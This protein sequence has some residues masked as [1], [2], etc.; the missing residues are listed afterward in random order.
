MPPEKGSEYLTCG[1]KKHMSQIIGLPHC[2]TAIRCD[3]W[4]CMLFETGVG[5]GR[6]GGAWL[7]LF[8]PAGCLFIKM[9][10]FH[11]PAPSSH[12]HSA[13]LW[14]VAA[15]TYIHTQLICIYFFQAESEGDIS[16]HETILI[17]LYCMKHLY[18]SVN[19]L[20]PCQSD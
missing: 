13:A 9:M 16:H 6:R 11:P 10:A 1:K 20:R 17:L 3:N 7:T 14:S 15:D 5:G 12:L 4:P 8:T 19:M 18:I 2:T